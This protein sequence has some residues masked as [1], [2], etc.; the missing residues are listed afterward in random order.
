MNYRHRAR[1]RD[2]KAIRHNRKDA[3][4]WSPQGARRR[5]HPRKK[6]KKTRIAS[7]SRK[8]MKTFTV[9]LKGWKP[10]IDA[11]CSKGSNRNV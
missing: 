1:I 7:D 10:C 9:D 8:E 3:L 4:D 11:L 5:G 6:W 2:Q